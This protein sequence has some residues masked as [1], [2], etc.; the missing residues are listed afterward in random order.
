MHYRAALGTVHRLDEFVFYVDIPSVSDASC[1]IDDDIWFVFNSDNVSDKIKHIPPFKMIFLANHIIK[2]RRNK[3]QVKIPTCLCF[4]SN[5]WIKKIKKKQFFDSKS[6]VIDDKKSTRKVDWNWPGKLRPGKLPFHPETRKE[7]GYPL[8]LFLWFFFVS[9]Q[10][11]SSNNFNKL[12]HH[13]NSM[14]LSLNA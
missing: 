4:F 12:E 3:R 5:N 1:F 7:F 8:N 11:N 9:Q 14:V 2:K 6:I 10:Q 13:M